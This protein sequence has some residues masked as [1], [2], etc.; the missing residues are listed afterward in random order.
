MP[1]RHFQ[2]KCKDDAERDEWISAIDYL[3]MRAQYEEYSSKNIPVNFNA[4]ASNNLDEKQ[5]EDYRKEALFDFSKK[6]KKGT[7]VSTGE[8]KKNNRGKLIGDQVSFSSEPQGPKPAEAL[9]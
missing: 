3:R 1:H 6:L 4:R 9:A 5:H 2:F 8:N 7:Q